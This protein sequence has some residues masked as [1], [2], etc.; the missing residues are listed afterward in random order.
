MNNPTRLGLVRCEFC[1]RQF[2]PHSAA[3]H[4]PWC[5]R[6]Q[7][8]NKKHR[9]SADKQEALERYRWRINYK[10]H[11]KLVNSRTSNHNHTKNTSIHSNSATLSSPSTGSV[12]S[13]S[14]SIESGAKEQHQV[15]QNGN[16][17]HHKS[18][19]ATRNHGRAVDKKSEGYKRPGGLNRSVSSL[20]LTKQHG[21]IGSAGSR[22]SQ[23]STTT[24]TAKTNLKN[25]YPSKA[26]SVSDLAN[27]S[28][29]VELLAKKMEKIYAQNK[30]LLESITSPASKIN[31]NKSNHTT[32]IRSNDSDDDDEQ[33]DKPVRC[34]HCKASCASD[35]N[36]CH[37]CGCKVK[38]PASSC[39]SPAGDIVW[40]L[41]GEGWFSVVEWAVMREIEAHLWRPHT[42]TS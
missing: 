22:N 34:H 1:N 15:N 9:L 14:T 8:E 27:M 11:N 36:Y 2:N 20:T 29:I 31:R 16:G 38:R 40:R 24:Y 37:L 6:Q 42:R 7:S 35:A 10:P 32:S 19:R 30:L 41:K 5:G 39:S 4:I 26:K 3:R 28:E 18:G 23:T 12:S 33:T 21:T 17:V 25:N 13:I